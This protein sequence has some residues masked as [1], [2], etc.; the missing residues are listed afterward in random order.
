MSKNYFCNQC[1][2]SN[3]AS[4]FRCSSCNVLIRPIYETSISIIALLG[5]YGIWLFFMSE[6]LPY[7][8]HIM[9][10]SGA[11]FSLFV[12]IVLEAGQYFTGWGII[13]GLL[14]IS[15]LIGVGLYYQPQKGYGKNIV[16]TLVLLKAISVMSFI[17]FAMKDA[18]PYMVPR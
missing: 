18:V 3:R 14:G 7:L 6:V 4:S 1:G 11:Q 12:R 8:A 9:S 2:A 5:F 13:W 17:L 15:F 10:A 16:I